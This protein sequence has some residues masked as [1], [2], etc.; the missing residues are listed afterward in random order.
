MAVRPLPG[1]E[2]HLIRRCVENDR[3]AQ[4]QLYEQLAPTL[5][6][7]CIRYLRNR[8]EAEDTLSNSMIKV[9]SHISEFNGAGSFE[10]WAKRITVRECLNQIRQKRPAFT[11]MEAMQDDLNHATHSDPSEMEMLQGLVASLPLGHRT[12]FN[13]HALEG[14][15]HAEIADEMGISESTSRI[16]TR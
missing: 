6:A 11:E 3:Q 7:L 16:A 9:F 4:R 5:M 14:Y 13:L 12:V 15:S 8:H 2:W 10:G 1:Q